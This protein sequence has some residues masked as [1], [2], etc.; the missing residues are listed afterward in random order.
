M[1][2][3]LVQTYTKCRNTANFIVII[4]GQPQQKFR[5]NGS[6]YGTSWRGNIKNEVCAPLRGRTPIDAIWYRLFYRTRQAPT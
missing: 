3:L 6:D 2:V 4:S 5:A 1:F